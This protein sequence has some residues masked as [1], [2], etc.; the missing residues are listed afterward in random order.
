MGKAQ[1]QFR[2]G[3]DIPV[4]RIG[5]GAMR[6]TGPHTWGP[7][8]NP[9][10]AMRVARRAVELGVTLIDTADAYGL[11]ANEEL[12]AKALHPYP[13]ELLI[14]TKA[15]CARPSPH[16]WRPLGRPEYLRQQVELSLR[17]L[18]LERIDLLQLH[19]VD[20]QVPLADQVGALRQL[21][22][23]GKIRHIGL[24]EVSVKQIEEAGQVATVVS[25]QNQYHLYDRAY[26]DVVE[27]CERENIA[28]VAWKPLAGAARPRPDSVL[29]R[30]AGEVGGTGPQVALAWLLARTPV[31]LPVP[32]TTSASHLEANLAAADVTL[33]AA[34]LEA[35]TGET[36][37]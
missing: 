25:V 26:D 36:S 13:P 33:T 29:A 37:R 34:Q 8:A 23:E 24:S 35:L 14:A 22:D 31:M 27:H 3:G 19:R 17:R 6:L 20:P 11:G 15:G 1:Q 2:I 28:F 16:Q 10:K 18:R 21:Q 12:L 4:H 9:E 7:P 5:F 30:V 32:G